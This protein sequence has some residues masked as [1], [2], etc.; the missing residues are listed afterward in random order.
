VCQAAT[1]SSIIVGWSA[2]F[3]KGS[4]EDSKWF[5]AEVNNHM[6]QYALVLDSIKNPVKLG[7]T[8]SVQRLRPF[9]TKTK[10]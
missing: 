10:I 2:K 4:T 3:G 1:G 7:S 8:K 6:C 5:A 9:S